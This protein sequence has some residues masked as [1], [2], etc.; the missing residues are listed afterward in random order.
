MK[1][2]ETTSISRELYAGDGSPM[3]PDERQHVLDSLGLALSQSRSEAINHRI[4]SG[5]DQRWTE[6]EEFY[7]G[8]DDANRAEMGRTMRGKP[9]TAPDPGA[10]RNRGSNVFFNIT[11]PYVDNFAARI[12]DLILPANGD[13]GWSLQPTPVPDLLEIAKGNIP[14]RIAQQIRDEV[15]Q[16]NPDATV[17]DQNAIMTQTTAD[18]IDLEAARLEKARRKAERAEKRITDWHIECDFNAHNRRVIDDAS[19]VG[20]GVLKGPFPKVKRQAAY[21][22]GR[23]IVEDVL[24]PVSVRIDYRNCFPDPECGDDIHNGSYHW[25]RD[26]IIEKRVRELLRDDRY[27]R[28]QLLQVLQEGPTQA[29]HTWEI[30]DDAIAGTVPL[31]SSKRYE[32]WYYYGT[33][34]RLELEAVGISCP[35]DEDAIYD[36]ELTI[37]N[38]HVVK[39]NMNHTGT[40]E[41]PYDYM[42]CQ[43]VAGSPWGIGVARQMRTPQ[44]VVNAGGR[45]MMN[46][47]G[48]A[49]GPMLVFA[50]GYIQPADGSN[51]YAIEP[52]KVW[53]MGELATS[54]D[55]VKKAISFIE[56]PM[57]QEQLANIITLGLKLAE[58]VTG[59]PMLMQG[60]QGS[61]PETVGGMQLLNANASAPLRRVARIYDDLIT[62]RHVK[63]YYR[64]LLKWGNDEEKGDFQIDARGSSALVERDLSAQEIKELLPMTAN[65]VFDLD[66]KKTAEEFLKAKRLDSNRFKYDDEEW[67]KVV[68]G[69]AEQAQKGDPRVE[70]EQIR[71]EAAKAI[72][73]EKNANAQAIAALKVEADREAGARA[74]AHKAV[75]LELDRLALAVK[76][77]TAQDDNQAAIAQTMAKLKAQLAIAFGADKTMPQVASPPTEPPGRAPAG[78]AYAA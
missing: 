70:V 10:A 37:I 32:I 4:T 33:L 19:K 13:K 77:G 75:E 34:N 54:I 3:S 2:N 67:K 14:D 41:F 29:V 61:A 51:D 16:K 8:I 27:I 71:T 18:V 40:G 58:D 17:E 23:L 31:K 11:R 42:V 46:N 78:E 53:E 30:R 36:V 69:L 1:P 7:E 47:A 63:R 49:G 5:I 28:D 25:E 22:N 24:V 50:R 15:I 59:M 44:R 26:F 57:Y 72:A 21:R 35:K 55:D 43:R 52:L 65:P 6:D 66:P 38:N 60:Q 20:T 62:E 9:F 64:Y 68:Q 48:L 76:T 39:A 73:S 74:D 12:A 45:N 56:L